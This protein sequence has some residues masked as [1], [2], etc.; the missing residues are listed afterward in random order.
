MFIVTAVQ[1]MKIGDLFIQHEGVALGGTPAE[2]MMDGQDDS[3]RPLCTGEIS[4]LAYGDSRNDSVLLPTA[5]VLL[6]S[7][8]GA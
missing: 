8:N 1:R 7:L 6:S 4:V 5:C 2:K 3:L